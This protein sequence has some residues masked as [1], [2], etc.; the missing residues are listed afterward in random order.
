MT[1]RL[2]VRKCPSALGPLLRGE[3]HRA[4]GV[5]LVQVRMG[6]ENATT[7]FSPVIS[8]CLP[9][10]WH[11]ENGLA[12]QEGKVMSSS[13]SKVHGPGMKTRIPDAEDTERDGQEEAKLCHNHDSS[14]DGRERAFLALTSSRVAEIPLAVLLPE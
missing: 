14:Q 5:M 4:F 3:T 6:Q 9:R 11:D 7:C 8:R 2:R 12:D 10:T 13:N 1:G